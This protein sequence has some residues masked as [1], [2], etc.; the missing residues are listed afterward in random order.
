MDQ[1]DVIRPSR[2]LLRAVVSRDSVRNAKDRSARLSLCLSP[3]PPSNVLKHR[4]SIAE[5]AS[6]FHMETQA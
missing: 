6:N 2:S 5:R 1:A 4:S 3:L